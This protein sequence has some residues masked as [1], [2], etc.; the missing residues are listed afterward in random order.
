MG[1]ILR[2]ARLLER[3]WYAQKSQSA[4]QDAGGG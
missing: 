4:T 3:E 1:G 2:G